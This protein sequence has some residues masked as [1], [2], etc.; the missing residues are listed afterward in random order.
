MA[1]VLTGLAVFLAAG[2]VIVRR[3]KKG[4]ESS[5]SGCGGSCGGCSGCAGFTAREDGSSGL[6]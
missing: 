6:P 1:T 5:A 2:L 3:Y 4:K